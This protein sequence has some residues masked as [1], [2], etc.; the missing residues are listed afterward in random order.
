MQ[1]DIRSGKADKHDLAIW[2][3]GIFNWLLVAALIAA[4]LAF[5]G[6]ARAATPVCTGT[7]MVAEIRDS[8]PELFAAIEAEAAKTENGSNLLWRV[9]PR[10]EGGAPSFLFGTMHVTDPRVVDLPATVR[11]A[12]AASDTVV[13]ESTDVIDQAAM[14]SALAAE[15]EL[16]MF[17]D[18]TT[19]RSLIPGD[20]VEMV[21]ARLRERGMPLSSVNRMKPW[22]LA[23]IVALPSCEFERKVRGEPI[24]D[25]MLAADARAAGKELAGL[26][27]VADQL[28]AMASLPM[29]LHV[30]GLVET[31]RLGD[32]VA[33]VLE[34]MVVLYRAEQVGMFWP[35]FRAVL[36]SGADGRSGYAAFEEIMV[37]ARNRTMAEGADQFLEEGGAFIAVGAL[38]LPGPEGLVALLRA[39]GYDVTPEPL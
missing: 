18:A 8:D 24:L 2:L 21:E 10:Q 20:D 14:M 30:E 26:E 28:G 25:L 17:T 6:E 19:L 23:S 31:L 27:S 4:F 33:D 1:F 35:F 16:T 3:A 12:F 37:N 9:A 22:M 34:T 39:A 29:E 7:D 32:R 36:P 11:E 38:H 15:P 5:S 13:I